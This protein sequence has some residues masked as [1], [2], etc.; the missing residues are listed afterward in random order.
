MRHPAGERRGRLIKVATALA[1]S[2]FFVAACAVPAPL[3]DHFTFVVAADM[4]NFTGAT[5]FTGAAKA[6]ARTGAGEFMVFPGDIDPPDAVYDVIRSSI[7]SGYPVAGNHEAGTASDMAWLRAFNT[8]GNLLPHF[9]I[10]HEPAFP[11]PD[12]APPRRLRHEGESLD[13]YAGK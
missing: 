12:A 13:K 6:I 8:G 4:R 11:Q 7:G 10:G 2:L 5:E 3:S 9:V 1:L